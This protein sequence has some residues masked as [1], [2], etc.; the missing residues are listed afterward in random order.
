LGEYSRRGENINLHGGFECFYLE[1]E[2]K[3]SN[4]MGWMG[5]LPLFSDLARNY[6]TMLQGHRSTVYNFI[7][8]DRIYTKFW[9]KSG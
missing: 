9:H 5:E 8:I 1:K 2:K 7:N 6:V 3:T 4:F